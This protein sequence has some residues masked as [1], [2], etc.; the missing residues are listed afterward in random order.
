MF[1]YSKF[2]GLMAEKR[3]TQKTL[4]TVLGISQNAVSH[5]MNGSSDF[6]PKEIVKLCDYF[7]IPNT[8][9]GIYFFTTK[10]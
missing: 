8:K 7:K 3:A 6:T 2:R 9:V 1:D 10:V 4:S 5:K